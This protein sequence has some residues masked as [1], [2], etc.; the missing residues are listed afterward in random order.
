MSGVSYST[1]KVLNYIVNSDVALCLTPVKHGVSMDIEFLCC[2]PR[3]TRDQVT[4][5]LLRVRCFS[6]L[7]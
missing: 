6:D 7:K 3:A 5:S 1:F 4:T 2:V